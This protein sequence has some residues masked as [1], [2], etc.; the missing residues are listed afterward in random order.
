MHKKDQK[1]NL[2][3]NNKNILKNKSKEKKKMDLKKL[4][5]T[6]DKFIISNKTKRRI[7]CLHSLFRILIKMW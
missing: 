6:E 2:K 3:S 4:Y 1:L 5:R 7:W